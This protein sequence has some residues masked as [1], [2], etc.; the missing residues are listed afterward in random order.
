[1]SVVSTSYLRRYCCSAQAESSKKYVLSV[2]AAMVCSA[3][4]LVLSP[5]LREA[6]N[7][8]KVGCLGG[9]NFQR[10]CEHQ[11]L[12][13]LGRFETLSICQM[14]QKTSSVVCLQ[15]WALGVPRQPEKA[16]GA[17]G[18]AKR[19]GQRTHGCETKENEQIPH[20]GDPG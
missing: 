19:L 7:L 9:A 15:P 1:M 5:G 16:R 14:M 4:A 10:Q 12:A 8:P 3:V 6:G 20:P 18:H 13:Q 2:L 17:W 11:K